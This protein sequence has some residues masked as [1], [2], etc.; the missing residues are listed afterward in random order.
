MQID[1]AIRIARTH[2]K[3][4]R[5]VADGQAQSNPYLAG[6]YRKKAE[7]LETLC[8]EVAKHRGGVEVRRGR[9]GVPAGGRNG[10]G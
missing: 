9:A 4:L 7:A 8:A 2:A 3:S 1:N 5:A 10:T 6:E